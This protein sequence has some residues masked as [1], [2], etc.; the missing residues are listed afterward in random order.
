MKLFIDSSS[1]PRNPAEPGH[2]YRSLKSLAEGGHIE[3]HISEI[4]VSELAT[5]LEIN[6]EKKIAACERE[7]KKLVRDPLGRGEALQ[8]AIATLTEELEREG[9]GDVA[10]RKVSGLVSELR[11]QVMEAEAEDTPEVWRRYFAGEPPFESRKN[12]K[13]LPDAFIYLAAKRLAEENVGEELLCLC[14]D[15]NLAKALEETE[16]W[17]VFGDANQLLQSEEFQTFCEGLEQEGKWW[18]KWHEIA[19]QLSDGFPELKERVREQLESALADQTVTEDVPGDGGEASVYSVQEMSELEVHW[20]K[21][22]FLAPGWAVIY[23]TAEAELELDFLIHRS[24]TFDV[25]DWVH[26]T[27]GDFETDAYFEASG[28]QLFA[29]EG[30]VMYE[31]SDEQIEQEAWGSGSVKIE[32]DELS[33]QDVGDY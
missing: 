3:M 10:E 24:D 20:E 19:P 16:N 14:A 5:Q 8:G 13:D 2:A 9:L 15:E 18:S 26:V 21:P 6:C 33:N 30:T 11:L 32:I 1:L 28:C 22:L 27:I 12:R 4:S 23:F 25:P 17:K 7:L 29:V 31:L